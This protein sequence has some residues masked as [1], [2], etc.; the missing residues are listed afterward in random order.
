MTVREFMKRLH[1]KRL[2]AIRA[3]VLEQVSSIELGS[4]LTSLTCLKGR[5]Q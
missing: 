4:M 5:S 3:E 2:E 1:E